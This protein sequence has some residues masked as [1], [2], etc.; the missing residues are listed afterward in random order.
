MEEGARRNAPSSRTRH[1]LASCPWKSLSSPP[2]CCS[3][4]NAASL[5]PSAASSSSSSPAGVPRV[6]FVP[7]ALAAAALLGGVPAAV[8]IAAAAAVSDLRGRPRPLPVGLAGAAAFFSEAS[9]RGRPTGRFVRPDAAVVAAAAV[10]FLTPPLPLGRPR[11]RPLGGLVFFSEGSLR[12]RPRPR[13][14]G[15]VGSVGAMD[16]R[17]GETRLVGG[18]GMAWVLVLLTAGGEGGREVMSGCKL[19]NAHALRVAGRD[20]QTQMKQ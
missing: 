3:S 12:G 16:G 6:R 5:P 1:S 13:L 11:G 10:V 2:D 17:E 4:S 14:T 15:S 20:L 8:V 18:S 19:V 7:A 9:F